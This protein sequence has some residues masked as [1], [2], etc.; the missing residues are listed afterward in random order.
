MN[1]Y[2]L[3]SGKTEGSFQLPIKNEMIAVVDSEGKQRLKKIIYIPG[4]DT[5]IADEYK[6]DEKSKSIWFEDGEVRADEKNWALNEIMTKHS[7]FKKHYVLVNEEADAQKEVDDFTKITQISNTILEESDELKLKAIAMVVI[8]EDAANWGPSKAKNELLKYA[9]NHSSLLLAEMNKANYESRVLAAL[10]FNKNIVKHNGF[11]TAVVWN[12]DREN[13]IVKVLEGENGIVKF[14]EFLATQ[15]EKSTAVLQRIGEKI[16]ALSNSSYAVIDTTPAKTEEQIREEVR[17]EE[18]AK[19]LAEIAAEKSKKTEDGQTG[20]QTNTVKEELT[21]DQS[22]KPEIGS[23]SDSSDKKSTDP[24]PFDRTD[25]DQVQS[26]YKEVFEKEL[27]PNKKK[28]IDWL[29][30][31]IDTKLT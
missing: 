28:D 14:G 10:A 21:G 15:S 12:D 2:K 31:Q 27:P 3:I 18:R 11:R 19:V 6:G 5:I 24:A 26:K 13:I 8:S 1:V 30:N 9:K 25:L 17:A 16:E 20:I 4:A 22:I 7:W 29:N 23:E